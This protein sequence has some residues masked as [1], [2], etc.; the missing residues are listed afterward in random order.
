MIL[1]R[2]AA[3]IPLLLVAACS[4]EPG[5]SGAETSAPDS[6]RPRIA[7]WAGPPAG[8]LAL[9]YGRLELVDGCVTLRGRDSPRPVAFARE[10]VSWDTGRTAVV[11]AGAAF[12]LGSAVEVAGGS[13][14]TAK[15]A[16]DPAFAL[17]GCAPGSLLFV[18]ERMSKDPGSPRS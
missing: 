10:S 13:I 18:V 16:A 11:L 14:D 4:K 7:T 8:R 6:S 2:A 1:L 3:L 9:A 5:E 17:D 12:P 15:A